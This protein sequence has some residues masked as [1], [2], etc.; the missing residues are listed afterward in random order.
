VRRATLFATLLSAACAASAR[1]QSGPA[2]AEL[3]YTLLAKVLTFDR[4]FSQVG[5][6]LVVGVLYQEGFPPSRNACRELERAFNDSPIRSIQS[7][8]IRVVLIPFT[9]GAT[10]TATLRGQGVNA[11]YIAPLRAVS[12]SGV[13]SAIRAA[14]ARTFT[15]VPE[16]VPDG[17]AVGIGQREGKPL[18]LINLSS[19]RAEGADFQST[20]LQL[21]EVTR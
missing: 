4:N 8:P 5:R 20:L 7:I 3:Q 14:G 16:Y 17:V 12:M 2:P 9:D 15:G 18:I 19:A 10:L 11:V 13:L 6:E 21:A 1:A